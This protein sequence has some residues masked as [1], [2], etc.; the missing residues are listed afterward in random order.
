MENENGL[1]DA[2]PKSNV[3]TINPSP[4]GKVIREIE[5]REYCPA[6]AAVM[7]NAL[8]HTPLKTK[9]EPKPS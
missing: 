1:T 8:E 2:S 5:S 9:P 6:V 4:W 7:M 3:L